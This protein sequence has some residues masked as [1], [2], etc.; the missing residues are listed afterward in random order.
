M[1]PT[2]EHAQITNLCSKKSDYASLMLNAPKSEY[3]FLPKNS[4]ILFSPGYPASADL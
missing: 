4:I 3:A 1:L 2:N